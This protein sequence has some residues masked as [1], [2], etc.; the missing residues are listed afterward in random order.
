MDDYKVDEMEME[1]FLTDTPAHYYISNPNNC[2]HNIGAEETLNTT[3]G[4]TSRRRTTTR[5]TTAK[6]LK[7]R[8]QV[9][10]G[11]VAAV[12]GI[13]ATILRLEK[14]QVSTKVPNEPHF[15]YEPDEIQLKNNTHTSDDGVDN[16]DY[17]HDTYNYN[18][19]AE[20]SLVD[21]SAPTS[22]P[23]TIDDEEED[24]K[25]E[26]QIEQPKS[27]TKVNQGTSS[28]VEWGYWKF[29][30]GY[31]KNRPREDYSSKY[32][33]KDIKAADLPINAWQADPV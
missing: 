19:T 17:H 26:E 13:S 32:P 2:S 15:L 14:F 28:K 1:G 3:T 20:L 21:L 31:E 5:S 10:L 30:D 11:L 9:V 8:R 33:S 24:Q 7:R 12:I 29:Y 6:Q 16:K 18:N 22:S 4:N 27:Q 25:E 23:I